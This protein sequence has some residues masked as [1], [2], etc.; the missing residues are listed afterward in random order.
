MPPEGVKDRGREP[1][2]PQ[3]GVAAL[4]FKV[5]QHWVALRHQCHDVF[6]NKQGAKGSGNATPPLL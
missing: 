3:V 4:K 1:L 2:S 6:Q 5:R